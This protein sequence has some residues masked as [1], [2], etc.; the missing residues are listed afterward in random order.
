[1]SARSRHFGRGAPWSEYWLVL[2]GTLVGIVTICQLLL[3][4]VALLRLMFG[5]EM[6]AGTNIPATNVGFVLRRSGAAST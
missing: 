2:A 3:R 1:M 4:R 6:H 5:V